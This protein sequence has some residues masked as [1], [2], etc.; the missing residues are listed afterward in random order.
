MVACGR[1]EKHQY[2]IENGLNL[3]RGRNEKRNVRIR[4]LPDLKDSSLVRGQ[5]SINSFGKI[6]EL[7]NSPDY[8]VLAP[9]AK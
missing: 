4:S 7:P 3:R 5:V 6:G 9:S 8:Q 1:K 2:K